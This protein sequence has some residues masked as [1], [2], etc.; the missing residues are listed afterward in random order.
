MD[1][2]TREPL[3]DGEADHLLFHGQSRLHRGGVDGP[4]LSGA[5]RNPLCGD[6]V[7]LDL[8]IDE[9]GCIGKARFDGRGCLVSQAGASLLCAEVEGRS[10]DE[11]R[12]MPPERIL[13]L[14]D[15]PLSPAR[16]M[17]ALLAY[18]C[19]RMLLDG[20][21]HDSRVVT[22]VTTRRSSTPPP[23]TPPTRT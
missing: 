2:M 9:R 12:L 8:L 6:H 22:T 10:I 3:A 7:R 17:C 11:A 18:H 15:I 13:E 20:T 5:L 4:T 21:A 23:R 1:S 14:V 19:L 16:R